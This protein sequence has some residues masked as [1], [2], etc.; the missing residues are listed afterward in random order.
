MF[1]FNGQNIEE[2]LF[3]QDPSFGNIGN[4][5]TPAPCLN[6]WPCYRSIALFL[7]VCPSVIF[8][9]YQ[10]P[11]NALPHKSV[12][13]ERHVLSRKRFNSSFHFFTKRLWL[14][15]CKIMASPQLGNTDSQNARKLSTIEPLLGS[16]S[17]IVSI[18]LMQKV[19]IWKGQS[20][21]KG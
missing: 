19:D 5:Q 2:D 6:T 15:S 14:I 3:T 13:P 9:V 17:P 1:Q 11:M 21:R 16:V 20:P 12:E 18:L 10:K 7:W 8:I 4:M